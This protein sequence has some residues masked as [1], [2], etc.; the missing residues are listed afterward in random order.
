[1]RSRKIILVLLML[2][3]CLMMSSCKK[4]QTFNEKDA[5]K[6]IDTYYEYL[7][8][9]KQGFVAID[10]RDL[11]NEYSA[12][13]LKGFI[14]YQY[15]KTRKQTET[16]ADYEKRMSESFI[17][18]MQLNY[19]KNQTVFLLDGN[20]EIVQHAAVKLKN[21]GYKKIYIYTGS[22]EKIKDSAIGIVAIVK[23]TDDCGC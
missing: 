18:W 14:S 2:S 19:S 13:H 10:L 22:F 4:T 21:Q 12:G 15:Y 6:Y 7:S 23:G 11:E 3:I 9:Q 20:G 8:D 17:K 1:M 5:S 16:D